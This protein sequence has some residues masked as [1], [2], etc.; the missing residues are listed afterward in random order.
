MSEPAV[1]CTSDLLVV[2]KPA[3]M[4]CVS[5]RSGDLSLLEWTAAHIGRQVWPV[6]RID[7]PVGGLVVFAGSAAAAAKLGHQFADNT[8]RRWYL[9]I[10]PRNPEDTRTADAE[11]AVLKHLLVHDRRRNITR[12]YPIEPASAVT[13]GRAGSSTIGSLRFVSRATGDRY[14]LLEVELLT[15]RHHQIRAQLAA[16]GMPVR[17]DLKYG[18]PRSRPGGGIDLVA[19]WLELAHPVT[20]RPLRFRTDPPDEPLWRAL[21]SRLDLSEPSLA[22]RS[23]PR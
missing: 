2:V 22:A 16:Q 21:T 1:L 6:H 9:A 23:R 18:A 20:G 14:E 5:D 11:P 13:A 15:G 12:A 4:P 17:G 8:A 19:A 10:V 3:G 7:R